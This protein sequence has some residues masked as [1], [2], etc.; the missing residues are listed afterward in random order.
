VVRNSRKVGKSE[1]KSRKWGKNWSLPPSGGSSPRP[2]FALCP[3]STAR[4][5]ATHLQQVPWPPSAAY[6]A[7]QDYAAQG[8][9]SQHFSEAFQCVTAQQAQATHSDGLYTA[10][11][12][13]QVPKVATRASAAAAPPVKLPA[14]DSSAVMVK[15]VLWHPS[16]KG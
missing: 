8:I 9:C 1:T 15:V 14:A 3:Y 6:A 2:C 10:L 11:D 7:S 16:C 13:H 5:E 4:L 12:L